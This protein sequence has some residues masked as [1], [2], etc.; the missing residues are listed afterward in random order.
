MIDRLGMHRADDAEVIGDAADMAHEVAI[1]DTALAIL[2]EVDERAG[3][4]KGGLVAAHAG[5]SLALPDRVRQRLGMFF[6]Q[7][8]F[9]VERLEL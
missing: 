4:R 9:R 7:E 1:L 2:L 8:G 5:Q 6:A 3:E